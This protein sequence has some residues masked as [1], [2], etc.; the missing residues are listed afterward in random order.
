MDGVIIIDKPIG[1]TSHKVTEYVMQILQ[2]NRTGHSGT[3]DPKVSGVLPVAINKATRVLGFLLTLPKEYVGVMHLHGDVSLSNIR[4]AIKKKFLGKIKQTPPRK[5]AVKRQE[6]IR[7]VHAFTIIEKKDKD[8]LFR[9]KVQAGTYIRKLVS[10]LGGEL[11]VGAHMTE[12]RRT[13]V[14]NLKEKQAITLYELAK[15]AKDNKKL[16]KAMLPMEKVISHVPKALL[17]KS[18]LKKIQY[19]QLIPKQDIIKAEKGEILA[20]F[21]NKKF[22][23]FCKPFV[24][25]GKKVLKPEKVFI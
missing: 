3:L 17:K 13:A 25:Q 14:G 18:S 12:L 15:I 7:E 1:P 10:D 23:A 8:V 20:A 19:G 5:C 11:G 16:A 9:V 24:S 6:R 2:A 21:V 22:I 4:K